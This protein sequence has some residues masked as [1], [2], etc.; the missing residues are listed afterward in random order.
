MISVSK[1]AAAS[2]LLRRVLACEHSSPPS[3]PPHPS[4]GIHAPALCVPHLLFFL[5]HQAYPPKFCR[6]IASLGDAYVK[7]LLRTVDVASTTFV[8]SAAI[9]ELSS[10]AGCV[11][12][13]STEDPAPPRLC[14]SHV[15]L[16]CALDTYACALKLLS[17]SVTGNVLSSSGVVDSIGS[18]P[19][20]W[21][22]L[23]SAAI[24]CTAPAMRPID[25]EVI[26]HIGRRIA[27]AMN[28]W[29]QSCL[30]TGA[31]T[32]AQN[33]FETANTIFKDIGDSNNCALTHCNA[34]H[35]CRWQ[36]AHLV[37]SRQLQGTGNIADGASKAV[38]ATAD[39]LRLGSEALKRYESALLVLSESKFETTVAVLA[40]VKNPLFQTTC[41]LAR[42]LSHG[43]DMPDMCP[44]ALAWVKEL[45]GFI[46]SC[47]TLRDS[48]V[49]PEL[50]RKVHEYSQSDQQRVDALAEFIE[51]LLRLCA[52]LKF[53]YTADLKPI[54]PA[55]KAVT[56][57]ARSNSV[58]SLVSRA[59]A[60]AAGCNYVVGFLRVARLHCTH[61]LRISR[62][63]LGITIK[64][65]ADVMRRA[66]QLVRPHPQQVEELV[67]VVQSILKAIASLKESMKPWY[68]R[69][70]GCGSSPDQVFQLVDDFQEN[71]NK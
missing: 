19:Q 33:L 70:L 23:W 28:E 27:S 56:L 63:S 66:C 67:K 25:F 8:S 18:D 31:V 51:F 52:M 50:W 6:C 1:K 42:A 36:W 5:I 68:K 59:L 43:C 12:K 57:Q 30:R 9:F 22:S 16:N 35:C 45:G 55:W 47:S 69:A 48:A 14:V 29:G 32:R 71:I 20:S 40:A 49:I 58:D 34:A 7:D 10:L 60:L 65:C 41:E 62:E 46:C 37:T 4:L 24:S 11:P 54:P 61:A 44:P 3:P 64:D 2:A 17:L 53:G 13:V 15:K 26:V 21:T 39:E 38:C